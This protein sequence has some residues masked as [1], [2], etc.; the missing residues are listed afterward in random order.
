MSGSGVYS[1]DCLLR[2]HVVVG[3]RRVASISKNAGAGRKPLTGVE[4]Q[5]VPRLQ[6]CADCF[7]VWQP[8]FLQPDNLKTVQI[9]PRRVL[10]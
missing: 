2:N 1:S 10:L 5:P 4:F 3:K 9:F 8:V 6:A 7:Q